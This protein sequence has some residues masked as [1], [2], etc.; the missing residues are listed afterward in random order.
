MFSNKKDGKW[1]FIKLYCSS[2]TSRH[3]PKSLKKSACL[4]DIKTVFLKV[5][6]KIYDNFLKE[7]KKFSENCNF[8][9]LYYHCDIIRM[10]LFFSK[11]K[12][13]FFHSTLLAGKQ[14]CIYNICKN[15][16]VE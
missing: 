4:F 8:V 7:M 5:F 15:V 1:V 10:C 2:S 14:T 16:N 13:C 9:K 11:K 6:E 3:N 12:T